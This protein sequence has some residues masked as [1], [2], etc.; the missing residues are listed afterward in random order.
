MLSLLQYISFYFN[1]NIATFVCFQIAVY[2]YIAILMTSLLQYLDDVT[3][4]ETVNY[5]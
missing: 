4:R 2:A 3:V 1:V 5:I